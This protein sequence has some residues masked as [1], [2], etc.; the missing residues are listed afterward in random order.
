MNRV[1][2]PVPVAASQRHSFVRNCYFCKGLH[3][4]VSAASN[5]A[6]FTGNKISPGLLEAV[7]QTCRRNFCR[8]GAVCPTE[9]EPNALSVLN[10]FVLQADDSLFIPTAFV[11]LE[12]CSHIVHILFTYSLTG[13][14]VV[15]WATGQLWFIPGRDRRL[16]LILLT[17]RIG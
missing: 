9:T 16:T 11:Q 15:G 8:C 7:N 13:H 14:W 12:Y 1:V 5:P 2:L 17:W 3:S 10:I 6:A 4:F